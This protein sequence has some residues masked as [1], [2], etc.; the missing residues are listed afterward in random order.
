MR[1]TLPT[2][3]VPLR[4]L[5]VFAAGATFIAV[6][7]CGSSPDAAPGSPARRPDLTSN[8][9]I[10]G[11]STFVYAGEPDAGAYTISARNVGPVPVTLLRR[12]GEADVEL[13]TLAPGEAALQAFNPGEA[14]LLANPAD[15][16]ARLKVLVWGDTNVGMRY[17]PVQGN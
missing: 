15:R 3:R 14:A 12:D 7:S 17:E 2:V 1:T 13:T 9:Q 11:G 8:L 5:T 16:L 4:A 10:E 6:A